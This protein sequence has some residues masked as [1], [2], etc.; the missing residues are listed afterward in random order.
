MIFEV[1]TVVYIKI[2]GFWDMMPFSLVDRYQHFRGTGLLHM[3]IIWCLH[4][5][6]RRVYRKMESAGSCETG[7]IYQTAYCHIPE[8]HNLN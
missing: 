1:L 7:Y 5:H 6:S 8:G 4:L 2:T 3:A